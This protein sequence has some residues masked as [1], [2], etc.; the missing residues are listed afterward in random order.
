MRKSE[1]APTTF[2]SVR[3]K[4]ANGQ[5]IS[6]DCFLTIHW[7]DDALAAG[8]VSSSNLVT[9]G[10]QLKPQE[11]KG[12]D[13]TF[14]F[15]GG[16]TEQNQDYGIEFHLVSG[17]LVELYARHSDQNGV[18]CPFELSGLNGNRI[19]FPFSETE[20]KKHFGEP[21]SIAG[22]WGH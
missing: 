1:K 8:S 3:A 16:A 6:S 15:V 13:A 21:K 5:A 22:V 17:R 2:F 11:Y 20:L 19:R 14:G 7:Q 12:Q 18:A 10:V 9:A 4:G